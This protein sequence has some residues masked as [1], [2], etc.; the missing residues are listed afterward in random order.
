MALLDIE[1]GVRNGSFGP[2]TLL[3]GVTS[4][5]DSTNT[6]AFPYPMSAFTVDISIA[7][8]TVS[9]ISTTLQGSLDNINWVVLD[10]FIDTSGEMAHVVNKPVMFLKGNLGTRTVA[11]GTPAITCKVSGKKDA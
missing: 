7:G 2:I 10:T 4:T 6:L 9:D 3:S 8:G 11:T 1:S 5:G